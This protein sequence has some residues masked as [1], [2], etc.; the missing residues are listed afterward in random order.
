M[1]H[2]LKGEIPVD[3]RLDYDLTWSEQSSIIYENLIP[4]LKRLMAGNFNPSVTQLS[5][6]LRSVHK[7]RRDR[8]R[9]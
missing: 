3:Y 9:K 7:H 8:L 6:W 4:E 2:L 5:N 1:K